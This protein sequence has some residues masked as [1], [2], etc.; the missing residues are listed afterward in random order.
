[1]TQPQSQPPDWKQQV[2]TQTRRIIRNGLFSI[3]GFVAL[4][5]LW[6]VL[7]PLS[8]AVIALG[9][10]ISAGQNKLVQH[11]L[12]GSVAAIYARDG[13]IV[14]AGDLIV[15]LD[16]VID[17]AELDR[18]HARRALFKAMEARVVAQLSGA[19]KIS[20]PDGF[21]AILPY[22]LRGGLNLSSE[23]DRLYR[24]LIDDQT[25][26]FEA[27]KIN[28]KE[29]LDVLRQQIN[30][31]K[32]QNAARRARSVS[33][34]QELNIMKTQYTR[35]A[36]VAKRG[37][38]AQNRVDELG[39]EMRQLE[40]TAAT[41]AG[42]ITS[43]EH[44]I[45]ETRSRI[46][47]TI[48]AR[49]LELSGKLSEDRGQI[50][51][52]TSQIE[53]AESTVENREI[54]APVSGIV[55]KSAVHTVGGVVRP[56]DVI[57]EIVPTGSQRMIEARVMPLDIDSVREGQRA[58]IVISAFNTRLYDPLVAAVDYVAADATVDQNS[59]DTFFVIRL[60]LA[61]AATQFNRISDLR[62]GM[63]GDVFIQTGDR[64][65]LNYLLKP[66][67]DSFRR[68]FQER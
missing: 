49:R 68:A 7:F 10:V 58:E 16:P 61:E 42:E 65:F 56:G 46:S 30:S 21:N 41:L 51:E 44:R 18:L 29:E 14:K 8:S 9:M 54:R 19:D 6:S 62:V 50:A 47:Q 1:M 17:R 24:Q 40:G 15:T 33:V 26:T 2:H 55:V 5:A 3:G 22:G 59:G 34:G 52:L 37:Y 67:S 20:F 43:T 4:F 13:Q 31:L 57:A 45:T 28:L 23:R 12:G 64:T 32:E 39:R 36:P 25:K 63:A 38:V 27:A 11:Q 53:A 48:A 60:K 66:I 35:M